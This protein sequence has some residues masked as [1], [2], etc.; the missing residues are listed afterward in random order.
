MSTRVKARIGTH[1]QTEFSRQD[2]ERVL[3]KSRT[4]KLGNEAQLLAVAQVEQL[5]EQPH[6]LCPV[7]VA[8]L[9][10]YALD[11]AVFVFGGGTPVRHPLRWRGTWRGRGRR[12][13]RRGQQI[14]RNG[15]GKRTG[16]CD[17]GPG[18]S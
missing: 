5:A 1:S 16:R 15:R 11:V 3:L 18:C 10:P 7:H 12:G 4:N 17:Y 8:K 2:H 6:A 14:V 13:G 9:R